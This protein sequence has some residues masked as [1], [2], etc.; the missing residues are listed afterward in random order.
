[1][2]F[3]TARLKIN[4]VMSNTIAKTTVPTAKAAINMF[5]ELSG[6]RVG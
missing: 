4:N 3:F 6:S 5:T 1:V 2:N